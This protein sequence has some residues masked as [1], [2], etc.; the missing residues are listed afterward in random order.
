MNP[1]NEKQ[2]LERHDPPVALWMPQATMPASKSR[3]IQP[4]PNYRP[5]L[6]IALLK[7]GMESFFLDA[8][9]M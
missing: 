4:N 1:P 7:G 3:R 8:R 2:G 6:Q 9:R 5:H